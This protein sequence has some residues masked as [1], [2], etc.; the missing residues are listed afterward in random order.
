MGKY[1]FSWIHVKFLVETM[2]VI[3]YG[4]LFNSAGRFAQNFI[5]T[6]DFIIYCVF[7]YT[8]V[9]AFRSSQK[10]MFGMNYARICSHASAY[11]IC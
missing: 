8:M 9:V 1:I 3:L 7:N 11:K 10:F 2:G 6:E 4:K 5:K